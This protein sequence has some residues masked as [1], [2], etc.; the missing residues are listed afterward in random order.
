[1]TADMAEPTEPS[2]YRQQHDRVERVVEQIADAQGSIGDPWRTIGLLNRWEREKRITPEMRQ[3]GDRFREL[4]HQAALDPLHA[5]D[6]SRVPIVGARFVF[7]S[8]NIRAQNAIADAMEA[9]GG[10]QAHGASCAWYVL[11]CDHSLSQWVLRMGWAG[12]RASALSEARG[13]LK[14]ALEVLARHGE[15]STTFWA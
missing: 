3:A 4:F 7:H 9:L 2:R 10:H 12:H 6:I 8:G 15:R 5:A 1:M 14:T 11:G 13:M